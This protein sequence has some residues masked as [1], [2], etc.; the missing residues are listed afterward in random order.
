MRIVEWVD[1]SKVLIQPF[2]VDFQYYDYHVMLYLKKH[3][4]Y[5]TIEAMIKKTKKGSSL[6]KIVITL[7]NQSKIDLINYPIKHSKFSISSNR[8]VFQTTIQL[9]EAGEKNKPH[10]TLKFTSNKGENVL[11]DFYAVT[12]SKDY[13]GGLANPDQNSDNFS[14]PIM[15]RKS[16]TLASKRSSITING[17]RYKIPIKLWIPLIFKGM[18]GYF[19]DG[20]YIADLR[21]TS[22]LFRL[23]KAPSE[24]ETG[25]KW[26]YE[27]DSKETVF[28]II[29]TKGSTLAIRG[30]DTLILAETSN[31][32]FRVKRVIFDTEICNEKRAMLSLDFKPAFSIAYN[33]QVNHK[34]SSFNINI[35]RNNILLTGIA[36]INLCPCEINLLL[37]PLRPKWANKRKVFISINLF[38]GSFLVETKIHK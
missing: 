4:E 23:T 36:E 22:H 21:E 27:L 17:I 8:Q 24:F 26:I 35:D 25:E 37:E 7:H 28:E 18:K 12:K 5:K 16:S 2:L 6:I 1:P 15:F 20:F 13:Y 38:N 33:G 14:L 3:P 30:E 11:F 10:I 29:S 9:R 31:H 19:T 34:K 32:D